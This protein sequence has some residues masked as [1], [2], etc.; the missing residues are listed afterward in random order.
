MIKRLYVCLSKGSQLSFLTLKQQTTKQPQVNTDIS[1]IPSTTQYIYL[2]HS[3]QELLSSYLQI[4]YIMFICCLCCLCDAFW[5]VPCFIPFL[6]A[7]RSEVPTKTFCFCFSAPLIVV[8]CFCDAL[9]LFL[10]LSVIN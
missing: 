2:H 8:P 4:Q 6:F 10:S 5:N 7:F 3:T 1:L 9:L